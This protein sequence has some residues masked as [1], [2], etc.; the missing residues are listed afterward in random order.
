MVCVRQRGKCKLA[1]GSKLATCLVGFG[2]LSNIAVV[3]M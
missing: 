3:L 1:S 2:D